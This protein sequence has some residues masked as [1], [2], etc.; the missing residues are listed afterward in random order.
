MRFKRR[1]HWI[2]LLARHRL[3]EALLWWVGDL[4]PAKVAVDAQYPDV[5]GPYLWKLSVGRVQGW[6]HRT[7]SVRKFRAARSE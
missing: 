4:W 2:T 1:Q 6:W 5:S 3:L 7:K